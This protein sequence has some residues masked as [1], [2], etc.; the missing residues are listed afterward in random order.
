MLQLQSRHIQTAA[1]GGNWTEIAVCCPRTVAEK[2]M[3]EELFDVFCGCAR[4]E[5]F[6]FLIMAFMAFLRVFEREV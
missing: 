4:A 5:S 3:M 6:F 2:R 1:G